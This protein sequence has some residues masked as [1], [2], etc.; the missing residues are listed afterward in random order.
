M[1]RT[2]PPDSTIFREVAY[3]MQFKSVKDKDLTAP[4][5][6]PAEGDRYIVAAGA[7]GAWNGKDNQLTE[8]HAAGAEAAAWVFVD[9]PGFGFRTY[10]EDEGVN[11]VW[12]GTVWTASETK[13]ILD[14]DGDTYITKEG[15]NVR[16][17]LDGVLV[18]EWSP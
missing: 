10:V 9:N 14:D 12:D 3:R 4:P 17:Y 15:G 16:I 5:G 2:D 11:Y 6:S 13:I 18:A 8:W 1:A 7:T